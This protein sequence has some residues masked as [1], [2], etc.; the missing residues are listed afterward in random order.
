MDTDIQKLKRNYEATKDS[1]SMIT[2]YHTLIRIGNLDDAKK[3]LEDFASNRVLATFHLCKICGITLS[4]ICQYRMWKNLRTKDYLIVCR[5]S[6]CL[7]WIDNHSDTFKEVEWSRG[8]PGRFI[9]VCGSC[10]FRENFDCK[11]PDLTSNGGT[12]L[13]VKFD[14]SL[15]SI[16]I[17]FGTHCKTISNRPAIS[18]IGNKKG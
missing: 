12:G 7:N 17:N 10:P 9:L 3:L 18:C 2:L 16:N 15:P 8:G 13:E 14:T 11:H 1:S 5:N 4:D 6:K